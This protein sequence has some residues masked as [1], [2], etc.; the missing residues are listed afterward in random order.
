MRRPKNRNRE[1]KHNWTE[2]KLQCFE[3]KRST[4]T[5]N[6]QHIYMHML[7]VSFIIMF[8]M[9]YQQFLISF[10]SVFIFINIF[11]LETATDN[12]TNTHSTVN[13]LN[14][15]QF[16]VLNNFITISI[17]DRL[18]PNPT[19]WW[20]P[21]ASSTQKSIAA[22]PHPTDWLAAVHFMNDRRL[23][24]NTFCYERCWEMVMANVWNRKWNGNVKEISRL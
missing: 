13:K 14:I 15:M 16:F 11:F 21:I 7:Y 4:L 10:P 12:S 19:G 6:R 5:H 20:I 9:W 8:I 3:F 23:Y 18:Q 17:F 2:W 24:L 1:S 22:S